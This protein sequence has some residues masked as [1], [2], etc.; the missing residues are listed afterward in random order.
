MA[1]IGLMPPYSRPE[2]FVTKT[3]TVATGKYGM[4]IKGAGTGNHDEA[5]ITTTAGEQMIG[6]I[7]S[8]GDPNNSGLFAVGDQPSV[9]QGGFCEVLFEAGEVITQGDVII[10]SGSD[11]YAKVLGVESAY[12]IL[13]EAAE[14]RTIGAGAG[15]AS[16]KVRIQFGK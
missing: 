16:V 7:Q 4:L 14:T 10:A 11:G 13:G 1:T 8:Q 12:W 6:V 15:V 9:A 5:V 3:M 2:D